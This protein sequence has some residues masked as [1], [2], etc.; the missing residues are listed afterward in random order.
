MKIC[1]GR[2]MLVSLNFSFSKRVQ[3]LICFNHL[4]PIL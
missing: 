4:S 3:T 2:N 1:T